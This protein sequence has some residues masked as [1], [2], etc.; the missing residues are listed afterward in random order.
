MLNKLC[1]LYFILFGFSSF[2]QECETQ[3][4]SFSGGEQVDYTI[5]YHLAGVWVSA[6]EVNFKV[7]T[8]T[9]NKK[10]YYH[11][12][13]YGVTFKK[14]DWI[15]KVRDHYQAYVNQSTLQP[16]RF[17][18]KVDEGST[19][20]RE[21]YIFNYNKKKAITLRQMGEDKPFVKDTVDLAACSYDVMSMIYVARNL[22]YDNLSEGDKIPIS[23]FLDNKSHPSYIEFLGKET[24]KVKGLG[25]FNCIKF[26][27]LLIEG[28]IFNSGDGMT[29]YVTDDKNRVPL[30][31]ETPILVGSIRA[32]V[33]K[34]EG[35]RHPLS[36]KITD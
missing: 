8:V 21:D 2:S 20:I 3:N 27:P 24:L 15:Y 29:V 1:F 12:D 16:L 7:D 17:K 11:L 9:I 22:N 25:E 18:R 4:K 14:Y 5:Y 13:S 28:T 35:L 6:G 33:N 26:S 31:I 19:H 30:L 32:R 23:I 34:M 36:S 10:P